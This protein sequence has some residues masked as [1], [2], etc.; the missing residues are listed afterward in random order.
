MRT[1]NLAECPMQKVQNSSFVIARTGSEG[2]TQVRIVLGEVA[3]SACNKMCE[4]ADYAAATFTNAR[5]R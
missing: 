1:I 4:I 2:G 5:R 3:A